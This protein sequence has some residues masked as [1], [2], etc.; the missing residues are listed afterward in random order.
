[1][2]RLDAVH[3][4]LEQDVAVVGE[5]RALRVVLLERVRRWLAHFD[6]PVRVG[7]ASLEK[8]N[9]KLKTVRKH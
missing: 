2:H 8:T 9:R 7:D 6:G 1:M 5:D 4:L 3:D